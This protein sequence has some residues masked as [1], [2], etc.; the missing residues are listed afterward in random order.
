MVVLRGIQA[1]GGLD[2]WYA[3]E[4]IQF[5]YD[6][7]PT[8]GKP[9]KNS[10]QTV[11][12]HQSRVYHDMIEPAVGTFAWDGERAWGKFEGEAKVPVHFWALT[13]YYF[14]G[15][16]FVFA[17]PG[18]QLEL[19]KDEP[20]FGLPP[21]DVV[22]VTFAGDTGDAPD[23][24]YIAHFAR[25]D[26]RLIAVRYVVS[27]K[28]F[29]APRGIPHTPEKLLVFSEFD[30]VGALTIAKTHTFYALADG[31]R[32]EVVT[33]ATV[34]ELKHPAPFDAERLT[35]P[36]GAVYDTSLADAQK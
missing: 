25:S 22:R 26:G 1:H 9:A 8:S 14:V 21:C 15:L 3:S 18:V 35:A 32:G 7:R 28:P 4:A 5:R 36:E 27:W 34:S 33:V 23:D 24:Y 29:V 2:A 13:P 30:G 16:P 6:Y 10:V 11:D 12:L 20:D 17:D 31:V 19:L